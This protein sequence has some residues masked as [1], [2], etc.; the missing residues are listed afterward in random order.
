MTEERVSHIARVRL[1]NAERRASLV[2][3]LGTRY[4]IDA[5]DED[6]FIWDA[7]ISNNQIDS[8]FTHMS[9]KT[10]NN[11]A[12]DASVGVA[13]L[14]G[15]DH[16]SIPLGYSFAAEVGEEGGRKRTT[17]SF[18]TTRS[19]PDAQDL[20]IRMEKGILR[21]VSVGFHGGTMNCDICHQDFW[22][23]RHYPGLKYEEKDGD[24]IRTVLATYEID[25]ANLSE[26]SGVFDGST[27]N[28]M[29]LKAQRAIKEGTLTREQVSLLEN[30]YRISLP[31]PVKFAATQSI[32]KEEG[33]KD[34]S[35]ERIR[36]ALIRTHSVTEEEARDMDE[37][38]LVQQV[39][40]V[41]AWR[42]NA[43]PRLAEYEEYRTQMVDEAVAQAVRA[44][45]TGVKVETITKMLRSLP[46]AEIREM[47]DEWK[48]VGDAAL[49]GG[50]T[51]T[52]KADEEKPE[53]TVAAYPAAAYKS[54]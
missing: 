43:E 17:A 32:P 41:A 18:Y 21:D 26:V 54:R 29:I 8:H 12:S 53:E 35:V 46:T 3:L 1:V 51:S 38:A 20:I 10:L 39:E 34:E 44:N 52:D 45:G 48:K 15:H 33:M 25:D 2:S 36:A 19:L 49:A 22:D 23:C 7:E 27:P 13:F 31:T 47:R 9:E 4:T 24:V 6:L 30:R 40:H 16:R 50:R 14:K 37:T 28:A 11:Y 5:D 42:T